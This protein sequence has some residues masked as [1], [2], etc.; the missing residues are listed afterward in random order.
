MSEPL[1]ID[2]KAKDAADLAKKLRLSAAMGWRTQYVL[3]RE[4][5][6][7]LAAAIDD[8]ISVKKMLKETRDLSARIDGKIAKM[9]AEVSKMGLILLIY[10]AISIPLL[11]ALWVPA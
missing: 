6:L 10:S 5:A 4:G 9:K 2:I 8:C 7:L 1:V 3:D 11:Y